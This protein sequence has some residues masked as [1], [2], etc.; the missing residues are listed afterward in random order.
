MNIEIQRKTAQKELEKGNYEKAQDIFEYIVDNNHLDV[1]ARFNLGFC[2]LCTPIYQRIDTSTKPKYIVNSAFKCF[3]KGLT[4]IQNR[5]DRV[6]WEF[7]IVRVIAACLTDLRDKEVKA[8]EEAKKYNDKSDNH[9]LWGT[10]LQIFGLLKRS[11]TLT[12][13][14]ILNGSIRNNFQN[15]RDFKDISKQYLWVS[16]FY[17]EML[18]ELQLTTNAFTHNCSNDIPD[19][20]LVDLHLTVMEKQYE[21]AFTKLIGKYSQ[22]KAIQRHIKAC[23]IELNGNHE[24]QKLFLE[25][26]RQLRN[27]EYT[28]SIYSAKKAYSIHRSIKID[29]LS[30]KTTIPNAFLDYVISTSRKKIAI[31]FV[32]LILFIFMFYAIYIAIKHHGIEV[33]FKM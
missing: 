12:N 15:S 5:S 28:D 10:F 1:V 13:A 6:N 4:M 9:S 30:H 3:Y 11:D 16:S 24:Y 20:D 18:Y 33:S 32:K 23:H 14:F 7:E 26:Q 2:T 8:K 27:K 21:L 19:D 31:V 17:S 25:S 22:N 29:D